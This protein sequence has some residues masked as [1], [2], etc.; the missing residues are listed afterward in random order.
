MN[1]ITREQMAAE[2]QAEVLGL[3]VN[4][5]IVRLQR[6]VAE[7]EE[8]LAAAHRARREALRIHNEDMKRH[9]EELG[10]KAA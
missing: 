8:Q 3:S 4:E 2:I 7:L 9:R 1:A 5:H 6:K 10:L